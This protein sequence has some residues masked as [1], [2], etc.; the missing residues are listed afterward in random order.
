VDTIERSFSVADHP[1][2]VVRNVDGRT[3]IAGGR[4]PNVRVRAVK[5]VNRA[6]SKEE[7][8]RAAAEV[9]VR[10]DQVGN[11]IEVEAIYP[12]Q[13]FSFGLKPQVLVHL[14]VT[15]PSVADLEAR[16]VDGPLNVEGIDG[17]LQIASTDGNVAA[18]SCAGRIEAR[19]TDGELL[20]EG[21]RGEV[22]AHS[23]DGKVSIAGLLN[24]LEVSTTDGGIEINAEDGSRMNA[25]WA[26]S[27]SDGNVQLRLPDGFSAD[28]DVTT[29]D[30]HITND[31]P[32]TMQ[33]EVSSH[34]LRG[35]MSGGGELLRIRTSDG[36]VAIGKTRPGH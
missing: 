17:H 9:Q 18:R 22:R 14:E 11:R 4:E 36:D 1:T 20:L 28:L 12:R 10:I 5:E 7:A 23:T 32:V 13:W 21:V 34:R 6:G 2:V 8:Q 33:G 30:G 26:I 27:S 25:E 29:G 16:T 24:I 35:K 3:Q 15:M 31:H 19:T